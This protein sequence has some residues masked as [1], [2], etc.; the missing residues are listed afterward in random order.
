M[1][2]RLDR[3]TKKFI[4][5]WVLLIS[6]AVWSWARRNQARLLTLYEENRSFILGTLIF[7]ALGSIIGFSFWVFY[8]RKKNKKI[9]SDKSFF[10]QPWLYDKK[11][12][13]ISGKVERELRTGDFEKIKIALRRIVRKLTLNKDP[14]GNFIH[15]RFL[16]TAPEF[17]K[18]EQLLIIHN[19]EY[20]KLN[21]KR[22]IS[23]EI[24]GEYLHHRSRKRG[25]LGMTRFSTY[26][27]LHFTHPPKGWIKVL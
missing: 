20:G 27:K 3:R 8:Q 4:L 16:I 18:G 21:L 5:V 9:A 22:G 26:G 14:I 15:Q 7:S 25:K 12:V 2:R 17:P 24:C 13:T 10:S 11:I 1:A 23:I 6:L 19:I